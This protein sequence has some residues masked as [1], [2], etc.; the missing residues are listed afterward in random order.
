MSISIFGQLVRFCERHEIRKINKFFYN[1]IEQ[2][3]VYH[4][5]LLKLSGHLWSVFSNDVWSTI[6][7]E[8]VYIDQG[9]ICCLS[10]NG[11]LFVVNPNTR[12]SVPLEV[13]NNECLVSVSQRPEALWV[14][15]AAGDI[16]IRVGL[17]AKSLLGSCWEKLDLHQI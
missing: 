12:S 9:A 15:T 2:Y 3:S 1:V 8:G 6:C 17:S 4:F 5:N 10:P 11:R 7:A 14:L 16:F 13:V